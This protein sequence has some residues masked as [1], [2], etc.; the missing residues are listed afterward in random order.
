[1]QQMRDGARGTRAGEARRGAASGG[2]SCGSRQGADVAQHSRHGGGSS[3]R[4]CDGGGSARGTAAAVLH[5]AHSCC[6]AFFVRSVETG[7]PVIRI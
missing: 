6:R 5:M 1:M 2:A 3:A 7:D 4:R